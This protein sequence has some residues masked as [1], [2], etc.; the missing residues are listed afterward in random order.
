M[1]TDLSA[2]SSGNCRISGSKKS[3]ILF[4][5][6]ISLLAVPVLAD[7]ITFQSGQKDYYF[8][9][10]S[11]AEIPIA[12][13]NSLGNAVSG[14][15]VYRTTEKVQSGGFSY[16]SSNSQSTPLT[17]PAGDGKFTLNGLVSESQKT[18]DVDISF[19]YSD[20]STSKTVTLGTI[21]VHFTDD[22]SGKNQKNP[23]TSTESQSS[24]SG[25]QSSSSA[26]QMAN[27]MQQQQQSLI[28]QMMNSQAQQP[29]S[30]QQALQNSQQSYNPESLKRQMEEKTE[31]IGREMEALSEAISGDELL[32]SAEE[33]LSEE[34]YELSAE[35]VN[36]ESMD[37][38]SFRREYKNQAGDLVTL[39]GNVNDGEVSSVEEIFN[40][41][42][43]ES[44]IPESLLNNETYQNYLV[45]LQNDGFAP[46][47]ASVNYTKDGALFEQIFNPSYGDPGAQNEDES[48]NSPKITADLS[49][50]LEVVHEVRL[51]RADDYSWL[52]PFMLVLLIAVLAVIGWFVYKKYCSGTAEGG[53]V[54]A[55]V[56][57]V[58]FDYR[59]YALGL[60]DEAESAFAEGDYVSAYGKAGQAL[61]IYL[62]HSY[63]DG[64]EVTNEELMDIIGH[65]GSYSG[66]KLYLGNLL[67]ACSAVEFAKGSAD[68]EQFDD[69]VRYIRNIIAEKKV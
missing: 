50:D 32:S 8:S 48:D 16:S 39:S 40:P 46:V 20:D 5:L 45:T 14:Q 53:S 15:M 7:E 35:S 26:Q 33:K 62:S 36:P 54:M 29:V 4:L 24:S 2:E 13:E 34:G 67:E 12:Y 21:T 23:Q 58:P 3:I 52:F 49:A 38:G 57:K 6:L 44:L 64:S 1:K 11:E 22:T 60:L 42:E 65:T 10:G 30:S 31:E 55:D 41:E 28:N 27:Q 9:T 17:L 56:V 59:K 19:Q 51:I 69:F 63:Y 61:R 47:S 43:Q 18:I 25:Q 37:E 66:D 68:K